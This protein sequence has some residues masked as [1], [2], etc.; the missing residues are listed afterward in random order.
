M[1]LLKF[2]VFD[3][4]KMS[5]KKVHIATHVENETNRIKLQ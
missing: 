3:S 1:I 2:R 4:N 5:G